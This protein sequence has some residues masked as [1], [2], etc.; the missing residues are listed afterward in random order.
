M[1]PPTTQKQEARSNSRD[2]NFR[3]SCCAPANQKALDRDGLTI[4][5]EVLNEAFV[6]QSLPVMKDLKLLDLAD[7]KAN[8]NGGAIALGHPLSCSGARIATLWLF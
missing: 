5:Y 6:A 1:R 3:V 2:A 8:L 4:D 7:Q